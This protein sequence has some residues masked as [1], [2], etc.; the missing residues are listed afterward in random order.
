MLNHVHQFFK[1]R[2][3]FNTLYLDS[4]TQSVTLFFAIAF[5]THVTHYL[6]AVKIYENK[7]TG[8]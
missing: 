5:L 4:E 1:I 8:K 6:T 2:E 3:V 7:S